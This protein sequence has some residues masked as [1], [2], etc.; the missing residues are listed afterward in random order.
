MHMSPKYRIMTPSW[1]MVFMLKIIV[2]AQ[3]ITLKIS[4]LSAMPSTQNH[5][6]FHLPGQPIPRSQSLWQTK[7][8]NDSKC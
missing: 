1:S 7:G 8:P 6:L 3:L 2:I 4:T 5:V